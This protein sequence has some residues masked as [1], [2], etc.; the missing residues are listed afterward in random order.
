MVD[1]QTYYLVWLCQAADWECPVL[2]EIHATPYGNDRLK[3]D[4]QIQ[5]LGARIFRKTDVQTTPENAIKAYILRCE[6]AERCK[7]LAHKTAEANLEQARNITLEN[8]KRSKR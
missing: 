1:H 5:G 3:A 8:I 4:R 7:R 6:T 2:T